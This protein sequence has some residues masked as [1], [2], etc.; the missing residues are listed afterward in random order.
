MN[1]SNQDNGEWTTN[2]PKGRRRQ[3]RGRGGKP[4][5]ATAVNGTSHLAAAM[6]TMTLHDDEND[7]SIE[8]VEAALRQCQN[9]LL[10]SDFYQSVLTRMDKEGEEESMV[11]EVVCY[12]IGNFYTKRSSAPLWQLALAV[13]LRDW[14]QERRQKKEA[15]FSPG[16][17]A[18]TT[19]TTTVPMSYFEPRMTAKEQAF[20][21]DQLQIQVITD[22]ERGCR[23]V[24][25]KT[26]FF[27]PHC[28]MALYANVLYINWNCLDNVVIFGNSLSNYLDGSQAI[29]SLHSKQKNGKPTDKRNHP[30][31]G[32]APNPK[33]KPNNDSREVSKHN[34]K[35][36]RALSWAL[37]HNAEKIGLT[38]LEDG[39]VPVQEIL[40]SRH[41]KLAS[42]QP[43]LQAIQ[44]VVRDNDKQR[45]KLDYR[46]RHLF[47][48]NNEENSAQQGGDDEKIL[49]IRANQGHSLSFINPELLLRPLS[50]DE[51][52]KLPC[53]VHGT[54]PD[55]WQSIQ[56]Q[57]LSKRNRTHIHFAPGLPDQD[58]VISGMRKSASVHIYVDAAK[59]AQDGIS[60]YQ[61]DN[62]V[63]LSDGIDGILPTRYFSH[64]TEA[65]TGKILLDQREIPNVE[66]KKHCGEKQKL[67]DERTSNGSGVAMAS[68]ATA[69][70]SD[71][72]MLLQ[73][74]WKETT[75]PVTKKDIS[76]RSA[77][78]EQAFNDSS[79]TSFAQTSHPQP[80]GIQE[81]VSDSNGEVI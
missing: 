59:C 72:L 28:P 22:N 11:Q 31:S 48:P 12:G 79:W 21:E 8:D 30:S 26:L 63:L 65:S 41:S 18:T 38:I 73:S 47:Y 9:E 81:G 17:D 36:S 51:L 78:F 7:V 43:T 3:R 24:S 75:I 68:T 80:E 14:L 46:P 23:S 35:L 25:I 10:P 4:S 66:L 1:R 16:N 45:F 55:A 29:S 15:D 20:L 70:A 54:F 53:I 27:M 58:H 34:Q 19:T 2:I 60:F 6:S 50:R 33:K 56:R 62:G 42:A 37:R 76:N 5:K 61:S 77:N 40:D 67:D 71:I 52:S 64:V 74:C 57:G 32:D 44:E 49:C 39:Y 69:H 13:M